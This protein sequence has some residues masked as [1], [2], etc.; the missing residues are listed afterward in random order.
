MQPPDLLPVFRVSDLANDL[1]TTLERYWSDI[2]VEGEVSNFKAYASS[3]HC[4]FTL[5]DA[6][7]QL[8]AVMW[9]SYASRLFFRPRD[10]MLVRARA[11]VSL[12]PQRGETQL[13]VR[14]MTLA[15]EGALRQA[16]EAL[17]QRL[18]AEGLFDS[19]LKKPLPRYPERIGIV[20]S[21]SGAALQDILS[22]LQ[23][24]FR[25]A[26]VVVC[27]VPVQGLGAA[28]EIAAAIRAFSVLPLDAPLRP[29]VLIVG[30][31]G[32]SAEDLWAFNEEVVARAIHAC[33]L[34]VVSAVGHE[35]D[36]SISD[37]AAD[38]R[39]ATPSM[40]AE[41]VAPHVAETTALL[42]GYV[43]ALSDAVT[44]RIA[45]HRSRVESVLSSRAFAR[46]ATRVAAEA[47]R[48]AL[49]RTRLAHAAEK[50]VQSART[51][52]REAQASLD[53]LDPLRPFRIGYVRV[54]R[55][56][57]LVS[58]SGALAPGDPLT[59]RFH[60]GTRHVIVAK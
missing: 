44:T 20:T 34:P 4:Y 18:H 13:V 54:E 42:H 15:G 33:P 32:G 2:I 28:E 26:E 39:A 38:V 21:A 58:T 8:R 51:R 46:P 29:D 1:R 7:A 12:Y 9:R 24:R 53:A 31:G 16:F 52:M 23:R 55:D 3:G 17:K 22:I 57:Q 48:L 30:R 43:N 10:G 50:H 11:T 49:L 14:E 25:Y 59:L 19:A 41:L 35:T 37:F 36:Y 56:G 6:D 45:A 27:G 60:D 5:K 47:Q 40:A